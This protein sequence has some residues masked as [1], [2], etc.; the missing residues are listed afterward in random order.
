MDDNK[1]LEQLIP[2]LNVN[3]PAPQSQEEEKALIPDEVWMGWCNEV[4]NNLRQERQ[5]VDE[6]K[7]NF[8]E[9]VI[10]E[11]DSTSASKEALTKLFEIKA[12]ISEKM[13]KVLDLATRVK[14][15]ERDTFP[16]YLAAHQNNTINLGDSGA[17]RELIK[18]INK[19]QKQ[20]EA[21]DGQNKS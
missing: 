10:N 5:E 15:K 17:K 14:L 12:G 19:I 9:M 20:K 6:V 3:V 11:G 1:E 7:H 21:N 18:Q 2:Q 4:M 13:T 16:R 8:I